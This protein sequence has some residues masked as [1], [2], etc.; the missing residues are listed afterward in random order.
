MFLFGLITIKN[1]DR[2]QCLGDIW[3]KTIVTKNTAAEENSH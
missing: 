2:N 1:T 3:A